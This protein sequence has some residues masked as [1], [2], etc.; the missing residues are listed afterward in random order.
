MFFL[1]E[2]YEEFKHVLL[3]FIFDKEDLNS[4]VADEVCFNRYVLSLTRHSFMVLESIYL[5]ELVGLEQ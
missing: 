4:P 5:G 2:A 3:T 1:K